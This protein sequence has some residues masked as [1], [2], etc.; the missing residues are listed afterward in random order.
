MIEGVL[1]EM[2]FSFVLLP[3]NFHFG[4]PVSFATGPPAPIA[5]VPACK[6]PCIVRGL[7]GEC[8]L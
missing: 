5:L 3:A 1:L 4:Y 8:G 2:Q 6:C 7:V